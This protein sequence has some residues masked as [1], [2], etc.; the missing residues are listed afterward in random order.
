MEKAKKY[1]QKYIVY[2]GEFWGALAVV[3]IALRQAIPAID[4]W[5]QGAVEDLNRFPLLTLAAIIAIPWIAL[6]LA[7]QYVSVKMSAKEKKTE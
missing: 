2:I 4:T 6:R 7:A 5:L 3:V 1:L